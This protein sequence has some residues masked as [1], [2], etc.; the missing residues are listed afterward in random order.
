MCHCVR[1]GPTRRIGS[2]HRRPAAGNGRDASV[3]GH[4]RAV[5]GSQGSKRAVSRSAVRSLELYDEFVARAAGDAGAA[6]GYNRTGTIE[7]ADTAE[8]MTDLRDIARRLAGR[9]VALEVLDA[10]AARAQEPGWAPMS[11]ARYSSAP[12]VT[13]TRSR[14]RARSSR[15]RAA[16]VRR[17]WRAAASGGSLG[18]AAIFRS[19]RTTAR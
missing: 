8:R 14:W 10:P 11:P 16:W 13:S 2:R 4:A 6:I 5:H 15:Q 7:I 3:G 17:S 18:T 9:G 12:T 1:T 19:K